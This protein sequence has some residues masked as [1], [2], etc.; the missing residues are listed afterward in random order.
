VVAMDADVIVAIVSGLCVAIPS[1]IATISSNQ[2]SQALI[3]YKIEELD[4]KVE[5]HN[6]VIERTYTLED[7]VHII[8]EKMKM[9]H[10]D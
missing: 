5:K 6:T 7:E 2:K 4:K 3:N 8:Q 10:E 9:Y 1:V